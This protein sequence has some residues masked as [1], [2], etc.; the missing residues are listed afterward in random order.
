[1]DT[2]ADKSYMVEFPYE[3]RTFSAFPPPSSYPS[4]SLPLSPSNHAPLSLGPQAY[5]LPSVS[6]LSAPRSMSPRA[7][8]RDAADPR[9]GRSC[10]ETY[11]L[12]AL[13]DLFARTPNPSI[14]ERSALASEIG[15]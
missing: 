10:P 14:E 9:S 13:Q 8:H 3:S 7:L 6:S 12:S 4:P 2:A 5:H 15:M 1:M 11:Q